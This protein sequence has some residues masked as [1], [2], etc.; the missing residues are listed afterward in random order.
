MRRRAS[1]R[2]AYLAVRRDEIL[3]AARAEEVEV[4]VEGEPGRWLGEA[5]VLARAIAGLRSDT[6]PTG[7]ARLRDLSPMGQARWLATLVGPVAATWPSLRS[8]DDGALADRLLAS[9]ERREPESL[10]VADLMAPASSAPRS[11][12]GVDPVELALALEQ[13][14]ADA[15]LLDEVELRLEAPGAS[16]ALGLALARVLRRRGQMGR[17]LSVLERLSGDEVLAERAEIHRRAGDHAAAER[18]VEAVLAGRPAAA[19]RARAVATLA[20]LLLDR[21]DAREA[22]ALLTDEP[23][24]APVLETRALAALALGERE[25]SLEIHRARAGRRRRRRGAR[26][27]RRRA[28]QRGARRR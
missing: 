4:A 19:A 25:L 28:R 7:R 1:V 23:D 9:V 27:H 12:A 20:R 21:G 22:A 6:P 17:A 3:Q 26:P 2:R 16:L 13:G 5:L 8:S 24:S 14:M 15:E 11:R 18:A 10:V